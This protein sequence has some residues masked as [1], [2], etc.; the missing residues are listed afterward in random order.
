[1][2]PTLNAVAGSTANGTAPITDSCSAM[3]NGHVRATAAP[4]MAIAAAGCAKNRASGVA[5]N[6]T[7]KHPT[8]VTNGTALAARAEKP[9]MNS[10]A[11]NSP[12][13][14]IRKTKKR[15]IVIGLPDR[16]WSTRQA[17]GGG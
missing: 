12:R 11:H 9:H 13:A 16:A 6:S 15:L 17:P 10:N 3:A 1:M 7:T 8:I 14:Q 4:S 5:R 2:I